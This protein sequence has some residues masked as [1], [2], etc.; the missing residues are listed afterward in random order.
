[1]KLKTGKQK[2]KI[3]EPKIWFFEKIN[4]IDKLLGRMIKEKREKIKI[5]SIRNAKGP[6]ST[7]FADIKRIIK[8]IV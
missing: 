7:D 6:I 8:D 4:K 5:T 3:S 1:M 2:R